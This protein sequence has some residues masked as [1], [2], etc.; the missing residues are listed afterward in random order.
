MARLESRKI[1]SAAGKFD[2]ELPINGDLGIECRSGGLDGNYEV[3]FTF[4]NNLVS[5]GSV[6]SNAAYIAGRFIGP[7]PNQYTVDLQTHLISG[8]LTVVLDTALDMAGNLG[9]LYG[10]MNMLVGDTNGDSVVNA[11]D[12]TQTKSRSAQSVDRTNFRSD[13]NANGTINATDTAI[14]KSRSG[15]SLPWR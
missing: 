1:H 6:Y 10:T 13:V 9:T 8:R 5:V 2:I 15:M 14:V 11:A 3:V 4:G 7:D 12:V